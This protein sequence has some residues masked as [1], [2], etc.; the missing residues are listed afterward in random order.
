MKISEKDFY[1]LTKSNSHQGLAVEIETPKLCEYN[2]VH[3]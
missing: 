2:T 3:S 1:D